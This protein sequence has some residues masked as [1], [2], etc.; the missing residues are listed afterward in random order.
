LDACRIIIA[1][2][3]KTGA[4]VTVAHRSNAE[5]MHYPHTDNDE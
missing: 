1:L 3:V 2:Q 4:R 5:Q